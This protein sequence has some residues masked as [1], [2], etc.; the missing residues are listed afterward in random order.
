MRIATPGDP[1]SCDLAVRRGLSTRSVAPC[2]PMWN[3]LMQMG[4]YDNTVIE[5]DI[6]ASYEISN[7][8]LTYTFSLRDVRFH[9]GRTLTS[10][11]VAF[12]LE[13]MWDL[14][15][16]D[17]LGRGAPFMNYMD[18]GSWSTPDPKT[19]VMNL[20]FPGAS[21]MASMANP[22]LPILGRAEVMGLDYA[23]PR[24]PSVVVGTGAW[25]IK[26]YIRGT[27]TE[28]ERNDDYFKEGLPFMDLY[29]RYVMPDSSA[30]YAAYRVGDL[31][32]FALSDDQIEQLLGEGGELKDKLTVISYPANGWAS[33]QMNSEK[34][35]FDDFNV[36][37][38]V[39]L[40]VD[41]YEGRDLLAEGRGVFGTLF[42]SWNPW[43]LPEEEVLAMPGFGD[44]EKE[45]A[46]A[47]EL[48]ASAG[49]P[50][51]MVLDVTTR[52]FSSY[53]DNATWFLS[54]VEHLGV[55]GEI[56]PFETVTYYDKL[57]KGEFNW[58]AHGHAVAMWDPD[59]VLK[60]HYGCDPETWSIPGAENYPKLCVPGLDKI[61]QQ[62]MVE[63]DFSKR[64]DLVQ[65]YQRGYM[66]QI[67][68]INYYFS[69]GRTSYWN[70]VVNYDP[71]YSGY[72][73]SNNRMEQVWIDP[74]KVSA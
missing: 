12:T 73:P 36:R 40:V 60:E 8:G 59:A 28:H 55:T 72:S 74:S 41:R 11:D 65:E 37:Y 52:T 26:E 34:A 22:Y 14:P 48:W 58:I 27:I 1:Q 10:D 16:Q 42:P 24:E 62:Q 56:F 3:G 46:E 30:R 6:A 50:S 68:K 45:R 43:G 2:S 23:S 20:K 70:W 53:I 66:K 57:A 33:A 63:L 21:F 67:G 35:P 29:S 17:T 7:G 44:K 9:N 19:I 31:D 54:Q 18:A 61:Y 5:P 51:S 4:M 47:R 49:M 25:K 71:Q 38:A 64:R 69:V 32:I 39:N 15:A 13:R